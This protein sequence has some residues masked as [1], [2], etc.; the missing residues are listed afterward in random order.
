MPFN[1]ALA[2]L[3]NAHRSSHFV[4]PGPSETRNP[5]SIA[6]PEGLEDGFRFRSCGSPRNDRKAV[7]TTNAP[8]DI[9]WRD[10]N[11]I[12]AIPHRENPVRFV[13]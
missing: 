13:M 1:R 7:A 4:I 5:E 2:S 11:Q 3:G 8:G 12:V 6:R 10:A 9:V